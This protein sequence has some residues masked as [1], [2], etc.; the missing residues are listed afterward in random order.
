M[1]ASGGALG[2]V[3]AE[4]CPGGMAGAPE[5]ESCKSLKNMKVTEILV[6]PETDQ[7]GLVGSNKPLLR[8]KLPLPCK[9][10]P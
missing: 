10:P 7:G 1:S 9:G 3:A 6:V 5:E 4:L 8:Q 2:D